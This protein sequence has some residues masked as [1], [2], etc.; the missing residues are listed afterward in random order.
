MKKKD[1]QGRELRENA[2]NFA[3]PKNWWILVQAVESIRPDHDDKGAIFRRNS[4]AISYRT[5]P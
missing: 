1:R 3:V 2:I 5:D 4:T